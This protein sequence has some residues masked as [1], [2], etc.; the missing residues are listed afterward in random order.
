MTP[1]IEIIQ[2]GPTGNLY[3][4]SDGER[5]GLVEFRPDSGPNRRQR[6]MHPHVLAFLREWLDTHGV[7]TGS[8]Q[9]PYLD[10]VQVEI[11]VVAA[12]VSP[13]PASATPHVSA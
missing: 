11:A 1:A 2:L 10:W 5:F 7:L 8:Q 9:P 3:Q 4:I 6:M 13:L 12:R